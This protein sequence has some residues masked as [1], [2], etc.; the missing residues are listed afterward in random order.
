MSQA[1]IKKIVAEKKQKCFN[2]PVVFFNSQERRYFMFFRI[3][4]IMCL[5]WCLNG[6]ANEIIPQLDDALL[7]EIIS[8]DHS[9]IRNVVDDKVYINPKRFVLRRE[10]YF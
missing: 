8:T 3:L 4:S 1:D 6:F 10:G 5:T 2:Q 7:S 9:C